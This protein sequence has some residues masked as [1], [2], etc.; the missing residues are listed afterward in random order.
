MT[1][2][3]FLGLLSAF[4]VVSALV[5]ECIKKIVSDKKNLPY[6]IVALVVAIVVGCIGMFLYY[7]LNNI[8]MT[9]N[10]YIYTGLMC[11]ASALCAELGYDKV[12]GA[13]EQI[14]S[15]NKVD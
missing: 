14:I 8:S 6:N 1:T 11:F 5:T 2:Y 12:K 3:M 13:I 7:K 15:I 10:D 4:S 9:T